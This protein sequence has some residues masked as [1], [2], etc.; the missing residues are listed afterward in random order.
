M[1]IPLEALAAIWLAAGSGSAGAVPAAPSPTSVRAP[2]EWT[3]SRQPIDAPA[4][5]LEL[6]DDELARRVE[7][8]PTAVGSLSIGTAGSSVLINAVALPPSPRWVIAPGADAWGTSETIA[9]I[10]TVVDTVHQLFPD[11]PPIYIGDISAREGGRLKRHESHQGGRDVDFGF[12][13]KPDKGTWYTPGAAGTMDLPRNW[14]LLRAIVVR[15]DVD[16]IFLDTRIQRLLY[17][18]ALSIDEDRAWLDS[19]F[20]FSRGARNAIVQHLPNHRTHYHVRFFNPV[21]QELGRRAHPTL[22]QLK[23]ARPPVY[24]VAHVVQPG[25]TLGELATRYGTS[26][27]AIMQANGLA[28]SQIRAGRT[29]RIPVR[30][31]APPPEPVVIR[32]RLLPPQTPAVLAAISWPTSQSINGT[33]SER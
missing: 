28:S 11:T 33:G 26:V 1:L 2:G 19:V 31:A 9:A 4:S 16:V 21:A 20:Q 23:L 12:F 10:D 17:Q 24:T 32:A 7:A 22:V 29:Y 14:A 25:Q 30:T 27:R 8:D 3:S 13:Y 5:L 15:T 18:Y 6:S